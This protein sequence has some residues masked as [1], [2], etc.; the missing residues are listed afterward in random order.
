MDLLVGAEPET[1]NNNSH[2]PSVPDNNKAGSTVQFH[3]VH[4]MNYMEVA[5]TWEAE[6]CWG[7]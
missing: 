5:D 2:N 6:G 1:D 4:N 7:W 3:S